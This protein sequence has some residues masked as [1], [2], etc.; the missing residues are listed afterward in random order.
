MIMLPQIL[1]FETTVA[2]LKI[3]LEIKEKSYM[4]LNPFA[5]RRRTGT[6]NV[7]LLKSASRLTGMS[8]EI[9][10]S[11]VLL[12]ISHNMVSFFFLLWF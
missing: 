12:Y 1:K 11:K 10:M 7:F 4:T 2:K 9:S 6:S 8:N 3:S 5:S